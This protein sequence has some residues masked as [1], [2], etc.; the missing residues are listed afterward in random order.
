ME[1]SEWVQ[2]L[3]QCTPS[4]KIDSRTAKLARTRT[5]QH[6]K[7]PLALDQAMRF[8]EKL[9]YALDFVDDHPFLLRLDVALD[10]GGIAQK[11]GV[12]ISF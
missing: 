6:E 2:S 1:S 12:D 5:R 10:A 11:L 7:Q 3:D 9:R 8:V 4:E